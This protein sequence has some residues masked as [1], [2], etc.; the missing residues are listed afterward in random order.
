MAI[1]RARLVD[2]SLTRWTTAGARSM[3]A[4]AISAGEPRPQPQG[5][6]WKTGSK[7]F[8]KS[9]RLSVGVSL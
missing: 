4:A 8:R 6:G 1:A 3:F 9:L 7:N 5:R 2:V